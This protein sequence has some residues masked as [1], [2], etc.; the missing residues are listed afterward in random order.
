MS[1]S[2]SS[3][4]YAEIRNASEKLLSG[5]VLCIDPSIGSHSS[6]PG[7][8]VYQAGE[9]HQSGTITIDPDGTQWGRLQALA[10]KVHQI[11]LTFQPDVLIYEKVPV[12]AHGGRSQVSHASLL[13]AVGAILSV[14]GPDHYVGMMPVSWKPLA[15]ESYIKSDEA[16]AV[17]IGWVTIEEARKIQEKDPPRKYGSRKAKSKKTK[18]L[19][20]RKVYLRVS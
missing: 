17:E 10:R 13:M 14:P 7:Y 12:S 15:R 6:M 9:L 1:V 11:I 19:C 20:L 5:V 16:D 4:T 18:K 2:K 3:Q 8:A